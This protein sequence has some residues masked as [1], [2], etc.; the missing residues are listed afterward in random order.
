VPVAFV[1]VHAGL[2]ARWGTFGSDGIYTQLFDTDDHADAMTA[3]DSVDTPV[4]PENVVPLW[5]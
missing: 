2:D 5:G 1:V 4:L 3:L